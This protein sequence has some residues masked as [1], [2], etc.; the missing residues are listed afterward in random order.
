MRQPDAVNVGEVF[1]DLPWIC[2]EGVAIRMLHLEVRGKILRHGGEHQ[3]RTTWLASP[4]N[5]TSSGRGRA[6]ST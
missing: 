5:E 6:K 3:N 1:A 4:S 2:H